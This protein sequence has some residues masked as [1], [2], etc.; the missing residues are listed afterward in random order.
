VKGFFAT[1]KV[2]DAERTLQQTGERIQACTTLATA[3]SG[4]L[5]DW[6]SRR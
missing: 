5:A 1:H 6:L 2:P 4:K 3:E